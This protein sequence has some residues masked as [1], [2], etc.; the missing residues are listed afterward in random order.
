MNQGIQPKDL[1]AG[2]EYQ[3][4]FDDCC[5]QGYFRG[6]FTELLYDEIE[7]DFLDKIRFDTGEIG[8]NWGNWTIKEVE[9]NE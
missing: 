5:V 3:I 9:N 1:V 6:K 8:P 2:K 7:V 4:N